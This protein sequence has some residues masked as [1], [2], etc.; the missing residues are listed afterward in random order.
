M[1][2]ALLSVLLRWARMGRVP[3]KEG[4]LA[5]AEADLVQP[6]MGTPSIVGEAIHSFIAAVEVP[7][8]VLC[9]EVQSLFLPTIGSELD[10]AG[11][12]YVRNRFMKRLLVGGPHTVL[13]CL[14]GS[15]MAHT[16]ISVARMPPNGHSVI[17][18]AS[19]VHLPATYSAEHMEWAWQQLQVR[20]SSVV[21]DRRLLELC[22]RSV[23]LLAVLVDAW[24]YGGRPS[25]VAAFLCDFVRLK[26][27]DESLR[28]WKLGLESMPLSQRLTVLDLSVP[29][30]GADIKKEL[31]TGLQKF[32]EPHLDKTVDGRYYLRDSHQRQIVRL[33]FHSDGTLW[34]SWSELQYSAS[35]TQLDAGWNLF[36]LG[37]AAD[38]LLGPN[39][40]RRWQQLAQPLP[41]GTDALK[42]K[43]QVIADGI[44]NKLQAAEA[45]VV[46]A[47]AAAGGAQQQPGGS[48]ELGPQELWERQPW[49]QKVLNSNWN[50]RDLM[51]YLNNKQARPTHLAMLVFYLRLGR[52]VLGHT[53]PWDR[54]AGAILDV[55][56][57]EAL[58]GVLDQPLFV[59]NEA[60]VE[61]LRLVSATTM[62][63]AAAEFAAEL[64]GSVA[65][66]SGGG[67][68][69]A[70][71]GISGGGPSSANVG[72][73]GGGPSSANVG[74][75]GGSSQSSAKGGISGG[76]PSS[77]KGGISGGGPSSAKGGIS[78]GGPSS[79]N[80]G[81]SGGGRSSGK[82]GISGGGPSSA[83]V[84]I[85][86]G[87]PSS[88][89]GGISGGSSQS[90]A[91]GGISGGGPSSANVGISGGGPSSANV[92]ISGGGRSSAKGGISGGGSLSSGKGG[93]SGGGSTS[94]GGGRGGS[95][96]GGGRGRS[97]RA[98]PDQY[99]SPPV[100]PAAAAGCSQRPPLL[101]T[102]SG[103]C[104]GWGKGGQRAP[105]L[106]PSR[107]VRLPLVAQ[108]I[109]AA[110]AA[111]GSRLLRGC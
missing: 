64:S 87:G 61:A 104:V 16:W 35:L 39:A 80:V 92:G 65:G 56:V 95:R 98:V 23:A 63:A 44:A 84:G 52:N 32:L 110:A 36:Y 4:A 42:A 9:D 53:K 74:I 26:V 96:G 81:I 57:I 6:D 62:A 67:P 75:G 88:A 19:A 106:A 22:P 72:I 33:L 10:A 5:A 69:S 43:L 30:V 54:A 25:D 38:Y 73:S 85:S 91:K 24:V 51:A 50:D 68:S 109:P 78:G 15:S 89:K 70:N 8:L 18:S 108:A 105:T 40:S 46:P 101:S 13:W 3:M 103:N 14:T 90:S 76:G 2:K 82:G 79:A 99:T 107:R 12:E 86:G 93:T 55:S 77:A 59:F 17:A 100:G 48:V 111:M 28:E 83:N 31:H 71:V 41:A 29:A 60:M 58:P 7:V 66:T 47:A 97:A 94:R 11:A 20:H 1:L 37:E 34:E 49:F 27:V 45:S 102:A 21:L